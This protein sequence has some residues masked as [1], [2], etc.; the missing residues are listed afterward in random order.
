MAP[1]GGNTFDAGRK[2]MTTFHR[3]QQGVIAF[4]KGA[5]DLLLQYCESADTAA[6]QENIDFMAAK[7]LRVMGFAYRRWEALPENPVS[8]IHERGLTILGFWALSI[9]RGKKRWMPW[10]S[11]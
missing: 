5:P 11:V 10:P 1:A 3:D 7:G 2:M 4:T 9:H 8:E 6:L